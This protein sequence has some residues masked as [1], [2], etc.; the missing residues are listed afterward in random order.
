MKTQTVT[1]KPPTVE[2]VLAEQRR[3][4]EKGTAPAQANLPA[5]VA[6]KPAPLPARA[7]EGTDDYFRR[8]PGNMVVGRLARFDGKD[9]KFTFLADD[10]ELPA[11]TP[12]VVLA[13]SI[14]AGLRR[15]HGEGEPPE[16]AGGLLFDDGY[17]RPARDELGDPDPAAW[18]LGKFSGQPED[19]WREAVYIPLEERGTGEVLTLVM[20]GPSPVSTQIIA[21]DGLLAHCKNVRRR[22]PDQY[23]VVK[24]GVGKYKNKRF[25]WLP[26]PVFKIVGMAAKDAAAAPDTSIAADLND[27]I[28]F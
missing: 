13:D 11:D 8:S 20:S 24:L 19:P 15:F 1:R 21:V 22:F 5:I 9:A 10:T 3:I 7:L 27:E 25:G 14:W 2:T 28:P 12:Y 4:T 26:K 16:H 17:R 23:P 6:E 18:P